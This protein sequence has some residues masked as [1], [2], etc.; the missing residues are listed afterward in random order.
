MLKITKIE[1]VRLM[2]MDSILIGVVAY[3]F[4]ENIIAYFALL[5]MLPVLYKRQKAELIKKKRSLIMK[6]FKEFC[7][8]LSNNLLVGY[9][10]ENSLVNSIKETKELFNKESYLVRELRVVINKLNINVPVEKAFMDFAKGTGV[11]EIIIFGEILNISKR[12]SGNI[13][14]IVRKTVD[15]IADRIELKREIEVIFAS[16]KFEQKVMNFIPFFII[17]YVKLTS[18]GMLDIM[19]NSLIGRLLMTICLIVFI[20]ALV[21]GEKITNMEDYV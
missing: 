18:P 6:E 15:S 14:D 2:L 8:I 17:V 10:F 20:F 13:V 4:Y 3:L 1:K 19:Y 11:D 21:L 16:K 5:L 9:S 7:G 12:S